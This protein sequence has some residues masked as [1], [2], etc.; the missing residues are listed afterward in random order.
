[1][2]CI[3]SEIIMHELNVQP[4]QKTSVVEKEEIFKRKKQNHK[5][6]SKLTQERRMGLR[7]DYPT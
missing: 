6:T 1:M 3:D 7:I 4:H 2:P 5:E